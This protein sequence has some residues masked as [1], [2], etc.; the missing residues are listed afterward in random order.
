M[1]APRIRSLLSSS[2]LRN[3]SISSS[4]LLLTRNPSSSSYTNTNT[5]TTTPHYR[6]TNNTLHQTLNTPRNFTTSTAKM[7][8]IKI[9]AADTYAQALEESK[10]KLVVIDFFAVWCGPCRVIAPKVDA[11]SNDYAEKASFY[12]LDV[13]EHQQIAAELEVRAMPTFLFFK[14]GKKVSEVVGANPSALKAA[15]DKYCA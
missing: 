15:L 12:K 7:T 10:T 13:D 3:Y 5:N 2:H 1:A 14:D 6:Y 8:V 4:L 9:E 11:F